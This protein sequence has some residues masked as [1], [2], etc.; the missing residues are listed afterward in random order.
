[1]PTDRADILDL[2]TFPPVGNAISLQQGTTLSLV[3]IHLADD[4]TAADSLG[5]NPLPLGTTVNFAIQ[6]GSGVTIQNPVSETVP[7]TTSATMISYGVTLVAAPVVAPATPP[8]GARLV[9]TV[10]VPGA[11]PKQFSWPI[12]ITP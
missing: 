5:G 7:N 11:T 3:G 1:M 2:G 4:N 8:T 9:L 12:T 6:G 10:G